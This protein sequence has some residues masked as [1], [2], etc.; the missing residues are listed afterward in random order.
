MFQE[1]KFPGNR[2]YCQVTIIIRE[3]H[4]FREISLVSELRQV[5]SHKKINNCELGR[6]SG[7]YLSLSFDTSISLL[8]N[9]IAA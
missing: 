6:S 8:A 2:N 3:N 5:F 4:R 7:D 1:R 9:D